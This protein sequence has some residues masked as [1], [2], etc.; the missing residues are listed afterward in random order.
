MANG[1]VDSWNAEFGEDFGIARTAGPIFSR[2]YRR[3]GR[4]F[5]KC[6]RSSRDKMGRLP[7]WEVTIS[8]DPGQPISSSTVNAIFNE[9]F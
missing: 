7:A 3:V 9:Y 5:R 4:R 6:G 2:S 8:R 1:S